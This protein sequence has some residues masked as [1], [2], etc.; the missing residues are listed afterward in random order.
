MKKDAT[1]FLRHILESINDIETYI[2]GIKEKKFYISKE[3][4][5]AVIRKLEIIGEASRSLP[6]SF[7]QHYPEVP[8]QDIADTRNKLIH[9]YFSVDLGLVWMVL[10][11]D[12]PT[13][14]R[15]IMRILQNEDEDA[16]LALKLEK[17][18]KQGGQFTRFGTRKS[19]K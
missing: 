8:W 2:R 3:K 15:Q 13:L 5:D 14:K 6:K 18:I 11:K 7:T 12:L 9:E 17:A 10:K 16:Q 1:V 19:H 4:H